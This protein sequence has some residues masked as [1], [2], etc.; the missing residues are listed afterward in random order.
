MLR[1]GLCKSARLAVLCLVC[2]HAFAG[3]T[4]DAKPFVDRFESRYR[5]PR[6]L[7][8]TFLERYTENGHLVRVE[9]GTAYFRRPGKMRW[10]YASPEKNLFLVDGK[11]AWFYVP[12]DRTVTRVPAKSS[13][14]WRTPLALLAGEVKV[15]RVCAQVQPAPEE[16]TESSS[17]IVLRCT[18]R[19]EEAAPTAGGAKPTTETGQTVFIELV[20]QTGE[21][22]GVTV[23]DPGGIGI[24]FR[25]ANWQSNPP[26]A[27]TSFQFHPPPGV[28]IVNGELP[29]GNTGVNP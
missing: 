23:K 25:F 3:V 28:A 29:A 20:R 1:H 22:A 2:A 16:K 17:N 19:G 12:A 13:S 7:Q 11:N 10:E 18:L 27:E 4:P 24:E 8:A 6:T 26:L 21:L 9:S 5:T 14:D 15:S